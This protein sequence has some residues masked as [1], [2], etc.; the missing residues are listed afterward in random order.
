VFPL[1]GLYLCL[2]PLEQLAAEAAPD[3]PEPLPGWNGVTLAINVGSRDEVDEVFA[4]AVAAGATA[5]NEPADRPYGPRAGYIADPDGN[6]WEIVWA[7]GTS[8]DADGLLRGLGD[9]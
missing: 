7:P 5:I 4:A 1:P 9:G 3:A 2:W 8:I 6:R